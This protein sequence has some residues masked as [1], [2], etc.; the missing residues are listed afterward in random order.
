MFK[1]KNETIIRHQKFPGFRL[2]TVAHHIYDLAAWMFFSHLLAY[3]PYLIK[4][5]QIALLN[6]NKQTEVYLMN[7][8]NITPKLLSIM[9]PQLST[10]RQNNLEVLDTR[11]ALHWHK[12]IPLT[13][14]VTVCSVWSGHQPS[15]LFDA[16][17]SHVPFP[18]A[19]PEVRNGRFF[20]TDLLIWKHVTCDRY[21]AFSQHTLYELGMPFRSDGHS[22]KDL[23]APVDF[24][25]LFCV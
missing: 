3:Q 10:V 20:A 13:A 2:G 7:C 4:Q 24:L 16:F 25:G 12:W 19:S 18:L 17:P 22:V 6:L 11:T 14:P 15:C 9:P 1:L 21:R 23:S 8:N 5:L